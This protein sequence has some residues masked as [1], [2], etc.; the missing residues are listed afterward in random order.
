MIPA[1]RPGIF[2]RRAETVCSFLLALVCMVGLVVLSNTVVL[3]DIQ[4]FKKHVEHL[5]SVDLDATPALVER[6]YARDSAADMAARLIRGRDTGIFSSVPGRPREAPSPQQSVPGPRAP[7]LPGAEA[8]PAG[9]MDRRELRGE[10]ERRS[11]REAARMKLPLV[12]V[13]RVGLAG[14]K[15]VP[16]LAT[17]GLSG[18]GP[19]SSLGRPGETVLAPGAARMPPAPTSRSLDVTPGPSPIERPA[20]AAEVVPR[21]GRDIPTH[22]YPSLDE[23]IQAVFSVYHGKGAEDAYFRLELSLRPESRILSTAKD[24]LFLVDISRSIS[25]AELQRIRE[26]VIEFLSGLDKSDRWNIVIFSERPHSLH[27]DRF[28]VPAGRFDAG[29]VTRFITRRPGER[30]TD[31]FRAT[32]MILSKVPQTNRPCNVFLISDGKVTQGT[33]DVRRIVHDFQR[34]NRDNFSIFTFNPDPEGNLFLLSLLSYRS[35][36]SLENCPGTGIR[37]LLIHF[38]RQYDAPVLTNVVASYTGVDNSEIYPDVLPNMYR[39]APVTFWGNAKPGREVALR[40][41]GLVEGEPREF[42]FKAR[43]PEGNDS[44]RGIVRGWARGKA[45]ALMAELGDDPHKE[46]LKKEILDLADRYGLDEVREMVAE[47]D[48]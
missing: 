10:D 37:D 6:P 14:R 45:F 2:D 39:C 20:K 33:T 46:K 4:G 41:V 29:D 17:L 13:R 48:F 25:V 28:F 35:R 8:G 5:F 30:L 40:V 42:F 36:G 24:I 1:A 16:G 19:L 15:R 32:Q 22:R 27:R 47:Y 26:A 12:A 3:W 18:A 44:D 43:V 31:V 7:A 21:T 11:R 38:L 9:R 34:V 23:E